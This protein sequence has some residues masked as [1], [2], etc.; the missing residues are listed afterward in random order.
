MVDSI[1]R[2]LSSSSSTGVIRAASIRGDTRDA[3]RRAPDLFLQRGRSGRRCL[4]IFPRFAGSV[5]DEARLPT[6][7]KGQLDHVEVTRGHGGLED[8]VRLLDHLADVVA[9][10][11]VDEGEQLH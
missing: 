11:D 4:A 10:G 2:K 6:L 1:L 9:G 8:L 7:G 3:R 5:W